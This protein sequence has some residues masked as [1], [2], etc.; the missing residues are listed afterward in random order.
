MPFASKLASEVEKGSADEGVERAVMAPAV[1]NVAMVASVVAV[2]A[3]MAAEVWGW[4]VEREEVD[5]EEEAEES[6]LV[7]HIVDVLLYHHGGDIRVR[8]V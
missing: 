8:R 6:K 3:V 1:V 7:D 5:V 2:T 4:E